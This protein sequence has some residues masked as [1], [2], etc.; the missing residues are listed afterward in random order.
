MSTTA[1]SNMMKQEERR[2]ESVI[3]S[4]I[5]RPSRA[6][7]TSCSGR[8]E[9]RGVVTWERGGVVTCEEVWSHEEGREGVWPHERERGERGLMSR[10]ST[11]THHTDKI[12]K[13]SEK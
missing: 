9:R 11:A 3:T 13:E 5:S 6:I 8:G 1:C 10:L 2:T 12:D 4:V 7:L